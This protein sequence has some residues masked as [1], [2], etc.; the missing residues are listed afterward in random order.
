MCGIVGYLGQGDQYRLAS[1]LDVIA[2]RG[3]DGQNVWS[4]SGVGL[5]H[6]RLA[7]IDP[8]AASDQPMECCN[9]RYVIVFNGEIYNF[10]QLH[11][12]LA[13][14][15]Y[16]LNT[17]S[18]TA[19]L[20]PLYDLHGPKMLGRLNGM[21]AFA[22][23]DR[24]ER[25]LFIAR[26][27]VGIKPLYYSLFNGRVVFASELKAI[28]AFGGL[29][30]Q[31]DP[32]AL[33][34]YASRLWSPGDR[35]PFKA[36]SK[37][38]PGEYLMAHSGSPTQKV[39][40]RRPEPQDPEAV[41]PEL[42]NGSF[43]ELFEDTVTDQC[44]SDVPIGAFLS[45][46]VDSTAIVAAMTRGGNPPMQTYCV[47][48]LGPNMESE[49]FGDDLS[50]ARDAARELGVPLCPIMV[51]PP[52]P[53]DFLR[54]AY[55]LDEPQADPAPLFVEAISRKAEE[56]GIKVLL[57]GAGGD[58]VFTG[59]RRH[60]SAAFRQAL[61]GLSTPLGGCLSMLSG[62]GSLPTTRRM[63]K[64]AQLL[65]ESPDAFVDTSFYFN[66]R[67]QVAQC[68]AD[69]VVAAFDSDDSHPW[70]QAIRNSRGIP[71]VERQLFM[72]RQGF[73]PDHNLNYTDKASMAHGVEVRVPFLDQ[74][75][76]EFAARLPWHHKISRGREKWFLKKSLAQYI[77]DP[78][79]NRKKT[80]FGA[81]IRQWLKGPLRS[82]VED[83]IASQKF[84]ERGIF[85]P[86]GVRQNFDDLLAGKG[87]S[88]Y[89]LL[90]LLMIEF[91]L[92]QFVD[93]PHV[94]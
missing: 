48:F 61:N 71:L 60:K 55:V 88:A 62:H 40:W 80:G 18:D 76:I 68:L 34:H 1:M 54:L 93:G 66:P 14:A 6:A 3:P 59:Y 49:G 92:Q 11:A 74:R 72:E 15:G 64:L 32:T 7:I 58:D 42:T 2:H 94:G 87:D 28:V 84:R 33:F 23:W 41:D 26:D 29:D 73:L 85:N 65:R 5:G 31:L 22:I 75:V 43:A 27:S 9:D 81:P 24:H 25:T 38:L 77:P 21:F 70:D 47:G 51:D 90:E 79:L 91:W 12:E 37:L 82:M 78:V 44:V 17:N 20:A 30:K 4:E 46:G 57:S 19:C 13:S 10:K 83:T 52:S 36:V 53:E 86:V 56:D 8:S 45:G 69:D 63:A 67:A 16:R 89:L 39:A 50:F 35:T